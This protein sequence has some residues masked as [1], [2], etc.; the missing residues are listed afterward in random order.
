MEALQN[1]FDFVLHVDKSIHK[2]I[3]LFGL[4]SYLILFLIIFCETGPVVTPFLPGDTLL[5]AAGAFAARGSFDPVLLIAV[6]L[7]AAVAGDAVNYCIGKFLGDKLA[8]SRRVPFFK[9]EYLDRTHRFYEK[10]GAKTIVIARFVPIV[11]TFAP[12]VAGVGTMTYRRFAVYNVTGALLW[13]FLLVLAGYFFGTI[14]IVE[15]NFTLVIYLIVL[16]SI[17]PGVIEFWRQRRL[18][19]AE[20]AARERA[21]SSG[22]GGA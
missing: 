7:T 16:V 2:L 17:M 1:F 4:W 20:A 21:S 8:R 11:R 6:L 10:Y 13:V 12:F 22:E 18:H 3:E 15:R 19:K 9:P 14:P 5:F